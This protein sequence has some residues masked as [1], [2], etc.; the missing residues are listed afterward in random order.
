[1]EEERKRKEAEK[2]EKAKQVSRSN[3]KERQ[4]INAIVTAYTAGYESTGKSPDHP[5]YGITAS[6]DKVKRYHTVA[7]PPQI[8]LGTWIL[9]EGVGK[10]QCT[11]RGGAIKGNRFDVYMKYLD[12][13]IKFGRQSLEVVILEG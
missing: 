4:R 6:G 1:M 8:E 5:A 10:R 11:D 2:R 3:Q 7:C 12:D 13:A 9:I